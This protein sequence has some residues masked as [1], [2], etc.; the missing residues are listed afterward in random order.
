MAGKKKKGLDLKKVMGAVKRVSTLVNIK[1]G[2]GKKRSS[3]SLFVPKLN[4]NYVKRGKRKR[5]SF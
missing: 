2:K 3:T 1:Q 5:G 4:S